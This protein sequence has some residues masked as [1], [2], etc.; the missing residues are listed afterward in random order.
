MKSSNDSEVFKW[1]RQMFVFLT[2]R[3]SHLRFAQFKPKDSRAIPLAERN[4]WAPVRA[5]YKSLCS[6]F[7]P[8]LKAEWAVPANPGLQ[9]NLM[10]KLNKGKSFLYEDPTWIPSAL[11]THGGMTGV[12]HLRNEEEKHPFIL[13]ARALKITKC[14][15]GEVFP[16]HLS[17]SFAFP[18]FRYLSPQSSLLSPSLPSYPSPSLHLSS[19]LP[20]SLSNNPCSVSYRHTGHM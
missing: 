3:I 19:S 1:V 17:R 20:L 9:H 16:H 14:V 7:K 6:S 4:G 13:L 5:A 2:N 15:Q 10:Q 18:V 12:I 11:S 8:G